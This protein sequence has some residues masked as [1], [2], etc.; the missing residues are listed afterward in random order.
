M[1]LAVLQQLNEKGITIP[2][3]A[4]DNLKVLYSGE[5]V[6]AH[7]RQQSHELKVAIAE[8]L[9]QPDAPKKVTLVYVAGGGLTY[10]VILSLLLNDIPLE[11]QTIHP[12]S[13]SGEKSTG[14]IKLHH[15]PFDPESLKDSIIIFVDDIIETSTTQTYLANN[16]IEELGV[17]AK[18]IWFAYMGDKRMDRTSADMFRCFHGLAIDPKT[19]VLGLGLNGT[20]TLPDGTELSGAYRQ[21]PFIGYLE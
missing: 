7:A 5:N 6:F 12:T 13:Y 19:Y 21:L 4:P 20:H 3:W 11:I 10:G 9:K 18:Y 14:K 8:A 17:A 1:S 16:A 15:N 2:T